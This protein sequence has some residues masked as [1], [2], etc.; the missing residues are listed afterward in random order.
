GREVA[1]AS[2]DEVAARHQTRQHGL[3]FLPASDTRPQLAN[4]LLEIA[5]AVRQPGNMLEHHRVGHATHGTPWGRS[6]TCRA[7][8]PW[9]RPTSP[10]VPR[11]SWITRAPQTYTS[12]AIPRSTAEP[13]SSFK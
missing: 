1:G 4:E 3:Q 8:P 10:S 6:P 5:F 12:P 11:L 9:P 13:P 7:P 2:L